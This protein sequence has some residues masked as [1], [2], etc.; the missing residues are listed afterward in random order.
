MVHIDLSADMG[1]YSTKESALKLV[2]DRSPST[3]VLDDI[4][5]PEPSSP[6]PT[7]PRLP[8]TTRQVFLLKK[9]WKGIKRSMQATGVEMFIG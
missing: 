5:L 8:L 3:I 6:I 7:D 2:G 4:R 9:S 1:C